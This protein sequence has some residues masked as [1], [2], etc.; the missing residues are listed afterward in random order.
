[1]VATV[2]QCCGAETICFRSGSDFQKVL[3][4]APALEPAPARA[5]EPGQQPWNYLLSQ[6]LC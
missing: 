2:S 3:A 6:I 4:P 1:M 5:P